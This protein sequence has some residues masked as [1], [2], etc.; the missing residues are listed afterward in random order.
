MI[1]HQIHIWLL[2]LVAAFSVT[3][4]T[5]QAQPVIDWY[6]HD[7]AAPSYD[8]DAQAYIDAVSTL[9]TAE[10]DV[11][12]DL[13]V[14]FKANGTWTKCPCRYAFIGG[15]AAEHKWNLKDP[16]D[17]DG[18][19]RLTF[20]GSWTHDANGIKAG[21][22]TGDY[23]DTHFTPS[24]DGTTITSASMGIYKGTTIA[25]GTSKSYIG[26]R[27]TSS[28]PWFIIAWFNSGSTE[29]GRIAGD[30]SHDTPATPL[31]T[32]QLGMIDISVNG[33][34]DAYYYLDGSQVDT[35]TTMDLSTLPDVP[36]YINGH[37]N[38]GTHSNSTNVTTKFVQICTGRTGTEIANDYTVI[39]AAQTALSRQN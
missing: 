13:V 36:I 30:S 23:G 32:N 35:Y 20:N 38:G 8:A 34:Q 21:G 27:G 3:T 16:Q 12:N 2:L 4:H 5:I 7:T 24:T 28:G 14:G 29:I 31:T 18:A 15:T 17:T 37:N 39:Q 26:A 33:S 1:K 9:T 19:F 10:Q 25:G 22:S 6:S 11:V